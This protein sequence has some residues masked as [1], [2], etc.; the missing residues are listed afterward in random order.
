MD[1]DAAA[2][3]L[4]LTCGFSCRHCRISS[5]QLLSFSALFFYCSFQQNSRVCGLELFS[6][7]HSWIRKRAKMISQL[8][9]FWGAARLALQRFRCDSCHNSYYFCVVSLSFVLHKHLFGPQLTRTA[10]VVYGI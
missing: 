8:L 10:I 4:T 5:F 6:S 9:G 7:L 3:A 1:L 2:T